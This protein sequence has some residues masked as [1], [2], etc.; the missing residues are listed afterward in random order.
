ML[1]KIQGSLKG[2][3]AFDL[4]H[5]VFRPNFQTKMALVAL[6]RNSHPQVD[7]KS[8]SLLMLLDLSMTSVDYSIL[9]KCL[10]CGVG[11]KRAALKWF[12]S[13]ISNQ[14]QRFGVVGDKCVLDLS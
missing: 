6:A 11:I 8:T 14:T 10:V 12:R 3:S 13:F 2:T 1:E 4:F 9:M 5:S 7:R